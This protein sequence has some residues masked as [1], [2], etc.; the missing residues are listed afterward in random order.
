MDKEV[1]V[2]EKIKINGTIIFEKFLEV[3]GK[4]FSEHEKLIFVQVFSESLG[5]KVDDYS[6]IMPFA[7]EVLS[8]LV[9]DYALQWT[10]LKFIPISDAVKHSICMENLK[11]HFEPCIIN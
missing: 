6:Q 8:K 1:V 5:I 11:S 2:D 7:F 3:R 4:G 9:G 10:K